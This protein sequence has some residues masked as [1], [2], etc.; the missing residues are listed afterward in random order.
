MAWT[1]P[2]TWVYAQLVDEGD[3]NAQIRDNLSWLYDN[4]PQRGTMWHAESVA[5]VG[6]AIT[7]QVSSSQPYNGY[8][9]PVFD[10]AADGDVFTNSCVLAAG[11]YEF[12]ALCVTEGSSG[13]VDFTLNG[14]AM[15]TIDFYQ[16]GT[17]YNQVK[18][19]SS[20]VVA[21]GG[22]QVLTG[23]T[24]GKNGSSGWYR[25]YVTKFWFA[26]TAGDTSV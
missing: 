12:N 7:M 19:L 5:T 24:N 6:L 9:S 22:R 16:A 18:T 20:I 11:T 25:M 8:A 17:N 26:P 21:T 3:L 14:V 15:G 1:S 10:P 23:T 13:K 4:L 2:A